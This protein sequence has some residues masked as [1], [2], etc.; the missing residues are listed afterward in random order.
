MSSAGNKD[1]VA[2]L[3]QET[4]RANLAA[5]DEFFAPD[6]VDHNPS[7][8]PGLKPGLEGIKQAFRVFMAATPHSTHVIEDLVAEGDHVVARVTA[9]GIHA[10]ELM[11]IPATGKRLEM[12]GIVIYRIESG[13][14]VERWAQHDT[15]GMLQQLGVLPQPGE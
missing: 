6:V 15:L 10:G 14:I 12:T 4:D 5:L 8:L 7:P 13:R 9:S 2:R 3:Y 11:G 1:L